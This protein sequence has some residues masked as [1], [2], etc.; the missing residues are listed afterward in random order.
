M[1]ISKNIFEKEESKIDVYNEKL[2]NQD[3]SS[4]KSY[5]K[6]FRIEILSLRKQI[7]DAKLSIDYINRE[8]CISTDNYLTIP[9]K[10]MDLL[11]LIQLNE[12]DAKD[13][14][15]QYKKNSK[16]NTSNETFFERKVCHLNFYPM[17]SVR[18]CN[19]C[20]WI[21]CSCKETIKMRKPKVN[22]IFKF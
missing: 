22:F 13:I 5:S 1:D 20:G 11:A 9:I 16:S 18:K 19:C 3:N 4:T 21:C 8:I 2:L 6:E 15:V 12:K 17:F 14:F 7:V 10:F